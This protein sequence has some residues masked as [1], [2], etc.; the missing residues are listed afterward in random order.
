MIA[1]R[2]RSTEVAAM[3]RR[4]SKI[5]AA[6]GSQVMV[7]VETLV[8]RRHARGRRIDSGARADYVVALIEM[9]DGSA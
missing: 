9:A 7:D 2:R 6:A 3:K 8:N 5:S 4:T 1:P